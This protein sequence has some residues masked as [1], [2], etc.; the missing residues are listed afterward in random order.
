MT[1]DFDDALI[2]RLA[3]LL[4]E[5]SLTEIELA[6]G[7]RRLRVARAP[8][9][10]AVAAVAAAPAPA[11]V[12]VDVGEPE[13][14]QSGTPILSPMVGTAY[15]SPEPGS[16]TFVKVGDQV[17]EGQTVMIVEAMKVMNPI[18]APRGGK[19]R[20]IV[21]NDAQ[22]VEFGEVLMILD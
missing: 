6:D 3:A 4:D 7:D 16:P 17:T 1:I 11:P 12:G 15:S 2:R 20:E 14:A 22:P 10:P 19:V 13:A 5:T 8:A 18:R 9:A 21:V